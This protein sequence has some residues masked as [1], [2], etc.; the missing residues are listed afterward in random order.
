MPNEYLIPHGSPLERRLESIQGRVDDSA[1]LV[2]KQWKPESVRPDLLPWLAWG[3]SVDAWSD[4]WTDKEKAAV[5]RSSIK[6]HRL[7]GTL[8]GIRE[9][10]RL[11]G[12]EY[13]RII[14]P[15][16]TFFAAPSLTAD[17]RE[18]FLARYPELRLYWFR[19]LGERGRGMF[20]SG[21]FMSDATAATGSRARF[22]PMVSDA[23]ARYGKRATIVDHGT[24]TDLTTATRFREEVEGLAVDWTELR[25]KSRARGL[26]V[27]GFLV[28]SLIDHGSKARMYRVAAQSRYVES[29]DR[30][31]MNTVKPSM[32][33]VNYD[34]VPVALPGQRRGFLLNG[35]FMSG[36]W[37]RGSFPFRSTA[38]DRLFDRLY[39]FDPERSVESR[40][41]S[42]HLGAVRLSMPHHEAE[43]VVKIRERKKPRA[44]GRFVTGFMIASDHAA[45]HNIMRLMNSARPAS[46]KVSIQ[47]KTVSVA[48]AGIAAKAGGVFAGQL[49][50]IA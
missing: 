32:D 50:E 10:I 36:G 46:V 47:T 34:A 14:R 4:D 25:I 45:L 26:F 15:P 8:A 3:M 20:L 1:P 33:P 2:A 18:A 41:R 35:S 24:E 21:D 28:G 42:S 5:V 16:A 13:V 48:T 39:L 29:E 49:Q 38:R 9:A 17:E 23:A 22:F 30:I 27:G 37:G 31:H 7:K 11:G 12:G 43:V 40:G 44:F 19:Q 6:F